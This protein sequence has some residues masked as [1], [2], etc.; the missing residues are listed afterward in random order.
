MGFTP[1]Q[2]PA[3][4]AVREGLIVAAGFS[5]YGGSFTTAAGEAAAWVALTGRAPDWAPPSAFSPRRL[6]K[7]ARDFHRVGPGRGGGLPLQNSGL[8]S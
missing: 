4:G 5:G 6:A 8:S 3:I 7:R 2:M 1:D